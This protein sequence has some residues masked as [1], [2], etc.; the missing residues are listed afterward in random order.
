MFVVLN[1]QKCDQCSAVHAVFQGSQISWITLSWCSLSV[2]V[3][4]VIVVIIVLIVI[5][6]IIVPIVIIV[7]IVLIVIIKLA[8]QLTGSI[9]MYLPLTISRPNHAMHYCNAALQCSIAM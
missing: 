2:I 5:N 9:P 4:F 1:C 8:G 3:L 7:I 6:V